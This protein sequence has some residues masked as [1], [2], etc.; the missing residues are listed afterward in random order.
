MFYYNK[1]IKLSIKKI[2]MTLKEKLF[3]I[4]Q[5]TIFIIRLYLGI[6]FYLNKTYL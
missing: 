4:L 1:T 3:S 5:I 6:S 2:L